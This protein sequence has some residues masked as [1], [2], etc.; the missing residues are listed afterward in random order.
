MKNIFV[1]QHVLLFFNAFLNH[2]DFRVL[3]KRR[4]ISSTALFESAVLNTFR[5]QIFIQKC[6]QSLLIFSCRRLVEKED[7]YCDFVSL[8]ATLVSPGVGEQVANLLDYHAAAADDF[9]HVA[10]P[11]LLEVEFRAV[12]L[13][14]AVFSLR[15]E[16]F[17]RSAYPVVGRAVVVCAFPL[18]LFPL[19]Q[20]KIIQ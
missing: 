9:G 13:F 7:F 15:Y 14:L 10:F 18:V 8:R 1:F 19:L 11:A 12:F 20:P 3:K 6:R 5:K 17:P 4:Q 16:V 2:I